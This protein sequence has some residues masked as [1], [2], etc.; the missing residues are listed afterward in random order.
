[1][2]IDIILVAGTGTVAF[3]IALVVIDIVIFLQVATAAVTA[4]L[5]STSIAALV[6]V[7]RSMVRVTRSIVPIITFASFVASICLISQISVFACIHMFVLAI[8]LEE[9]FDG[10]TMWEPLEITVTLTYL[11]YNR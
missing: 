6:R 4:V 3:V 9:L 5:P 1:M 2:L 7:T 10:P 11:E 8:G